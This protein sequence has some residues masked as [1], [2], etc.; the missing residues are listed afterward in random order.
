MRHDRAVAFEAQ[1]SPGKRYVQGGG[2]LGA[3]FGAFIAMLLSA[4]VLGLGGPPWT[5]AIPVALGGWVG[6]RL[7]DRFHHWVLEKIRDWWWL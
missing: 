2:V 6:A 5:Y 7:G 1:P 3:L 4:D